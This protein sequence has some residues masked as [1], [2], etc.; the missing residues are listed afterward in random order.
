VNLDDIVTRLNERK[1]R[2]TYGAVAGI[3]GVL[4]RGVM[5][6]RQKNHK[7]SWVVAATGSWRGWPTG[8]TNEQIHPDCLRQIRDHLDNLIE[9]SAELRR[10]LST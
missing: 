7:Y 3:L 6:G 2:A 9:N 8:Y 5:G 10:W 1:Q 4:P